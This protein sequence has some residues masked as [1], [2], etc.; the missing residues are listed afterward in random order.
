[1]CIHKCT[2]YKYKN[3]NA[4][5]YRCT[6][7]NFDNLLELGNRQNFK[8]FY[9]ESEM[10]EIF[11]NVC[12]MCPNTSK[13][14]QLSQVTNKCISWLQSKTEKDDSD[15]T[16]LQCFTQRKVQNK[17]SSNPFKLQAPSDPEV[18]SRSLAA[19]AA[20]ALTMGRFGF[21]MPSSTSLS[22]QLWAYSRRSSSAS[23]PK[24]IRNQAATARATSPYPIGSLLRNS[25]SS[26][27]IGKN[28]RKSHKTALHVYCC[29]CCWNMLASLTWKET[30]MS[31]IS[32][33]L[34][35]AFFPLSAPMAASKKPPTTQ[36]DGRKKTQALYILYYY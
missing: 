23:A 4:T 29:Q 9:G 16:L 13:P 24:K 21:L 34:Q 17:P 36:E 14:G 28:W 25:V 1:M 10:S 35:L 18:F 30:N 3:R 15:K 20:E 6:T 8:V 7:L 31:C 5:L 2:I 12:I 11:R 26:N 32:T 19:A 33:R 22:R 27:L